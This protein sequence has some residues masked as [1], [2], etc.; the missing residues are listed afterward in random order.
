VPFLF[1]L[2]FATDAELVP[3]LAPTGALLLA[4]CAGALWAGHR[5]RLVWLGPA[6]AAAASGVLATWLLGHPLD[7]RGSWEL[8][9]T[10]V[11]LALLMQLGLEVDRRVSRGAAPES[12]MPL[13]RSLGAAVP[14]AAGLGL[15]LIGAGWSGPV[16]WPWIAGA[17]ALAAIGARHAHATGRPWLEIAAATMVGAVLAV[18]HLAKGHHPGF[19][20]P[21]IHLSVCVAV[22]AAALL[23]A[24]LRPRPA[25]GDAAAALAAVLLF[26]LALLGGSIAIHPLLFL[27]TALVLGVLILASAARTGHGG[28]LLVAAAGVAAACWQW[29][30]LPGGNGGWPLALAT[31]AFAML[32]FLAAPF[33]LA[34]LR[35]SRWAWRSAA[36]A[37]VLFFLPIH[38]AFVAGFG[39][40]AI[41]LVPLALAAV[42]FAALAATRL[43]GP[44]AVDVRATARV[45][46]A[47]V[48]IAFVTLAV[49]MQL[50]DEQI[51]VAWA[52]EG[53][54][55][56]ALWRRHDHA[57]LKYAG[58]GLL[59]TVTIRLVANPY[60]LQ[61]H[62]PS[63]LPVLNWIA[64]T[65]LVPL[66]AL[67]AAW[68]LLRGHEVERLRPWERSSYPA[69]RPLGAEL[70]VLCAVAVGFVWINLAII[71]WYADGPTLSIPV[72][73]MPARDLTTSLAWALYAVVLLAFGMWRESFAL[74]A[75]SL[76][77]VLLTCAKVFLHDLAH[78]EDLYRVAS[79]AG[80][81]VSL[82]GISV[83][84]QRFVFRVR[85]TGA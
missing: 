79:F 70:A 56:V 4:L 43:A 78:L 17:L 57:G 29:R 50:A 25:A 13:L 84:Y 3:H 82:L 16:V 30:D 5:H 66:A 53:A 19:P 61:Y 49:P 59:A 1:A 73:R 48:A 62:P 81:A 63:A 41:G 47:S 20:P 36:I 24:V 46:T 10:A 22:A 55:L 69:V 76:A 15:M 58:L 42:S 14:L 85:A 64:V 27:G 60:V 32:L 33:F 44:R 2:L 67:L 6:A 52:I 75:L 23:S 34:R 65:Y 80:L 68:L 74:R 72:D 35:E 54:L 45:F 18:L 28:W 77:L 51:T 7:A 71:D 8:V 26:H 83:A 39:D 40:G 11:L 21:A 38:S 9:A 31:A 37:P 12:P